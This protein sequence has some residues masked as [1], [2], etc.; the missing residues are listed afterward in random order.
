MVMQYL[1][2]YYF[3]AAG[4][5]GKIHIQ[6]LISEN[7]ILFVNNN[8]ILLSP[9]LKGKANGSSSNVL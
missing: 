3:E 4:V 1:N 8:I 2:I 7:V 5:F 6:S 9:N